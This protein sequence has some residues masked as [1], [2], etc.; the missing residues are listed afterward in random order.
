MPQNELQELARLIR[1]LRDLA[2]Q[3][4]ELSKTVPAAEKNLYMIL[5][6][7]EMLEIEVCDTVRALEEGE[8]ERRNRG[9][10]GAER[11]GR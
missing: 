7:L 5:R 1:Q 10:R 3:A 11:G 6:H 8:R 4:H 9:D 2:E